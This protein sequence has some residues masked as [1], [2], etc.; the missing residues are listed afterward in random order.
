MRDYFIRRL[1]LIIPTL[2]GVT[3]IVFMITRFVP[4]GPMEQALAQMRAVQVGGG[5]GVGQ[6]MSLSEDQLEDL[7]KLYGFDKPAIVAYF[8]WLGQALQGSLGDSF[9]YQEPVTKLMAERLPISAYFGIVTLIIT[10]VVCVP[11]GIVKAIQH[12]SPMDNLTSILVFVGYAVPGYVLG[13]LLLYLFSFKLGWL[14]ASGFVSADFEDKGFFGKVG[15][16]VSHTVQP[17]ICYLIGNF[18]F[19]TFLMKNHLLEN[20]AADYVRTAVAKGVEFKDAVRIH[21]LRNSLIPVATNLGHQVSVL[22]AGS[23]LIETIFDIDGFGLLGFKSALDRDYP[24]VMGVVL[25]S[26]VL[27]MIGNILSDVLVALVD[28]RIRFK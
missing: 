10:Y 27:M 23:F 7:K 14:P 24:V 13:V 16:L 12:Q 3:L 2:L 5:G 15:D 22:I 20:L 11:L 19:V 6:E 9:I 18:A 26:A 17:L 1:L 21:A 4:G 28:P 25:L 8:H